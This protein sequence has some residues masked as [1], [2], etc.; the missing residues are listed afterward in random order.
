IY[1]NVDNEALM[2]HPLWA[3]PVM[4]G[5]VFDYLLRKLVQAELGR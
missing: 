4:I 3:A 5:P 1:F 2:H